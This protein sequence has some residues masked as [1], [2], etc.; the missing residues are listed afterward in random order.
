M[1]ERTVT[2]PDG[3][4]LGRDWWRTAIIDM[5]PRVIRYRG[6][7][8]ED[9]I[10]QRVGLAQMV[11]L[12]TRADLPTRP[13]GAGAAGAVKPGCPQAGQWAPVRRRDVM[14][15]EAGAAPATEDHP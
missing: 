3:E 15:H 4:Q 6:H 10:R 11:W 9:L 12:M 2:P 1:S 13:P 14:V 8:I 7:A 5:A